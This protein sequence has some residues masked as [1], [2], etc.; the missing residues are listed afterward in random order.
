MITIPAFRY[1]PYIFIIIVSLLTG[2]TS[3]YLLMRHFKLSRQTAL[4]TTFLCLITATYTSVMTAFI[5]TGKFTASGLGAALGIL[6]GVFISTGIFKENENI[7]FASFITAMPLMYGIAKTACLF[8]GCC[9]GMAVHRGIR[10]CYAGIDPTLCYFPSPI[11]ESVAF[12][13]I[14]ITALILLLKK[15]DF[16]RASR[17]ALILAFIARFGLDFLRYSH[18]YKFITT[19]QILTIAGGFIALTYILIRRKKDVT[20]NN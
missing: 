12:I 16:K 15:N 7:F 9:K 2:M 5:A 4:L 20:Q 11:V 13:A 18:T 17:T 10:I 1:S 14:H 19:D 8:S 3:A 6:I